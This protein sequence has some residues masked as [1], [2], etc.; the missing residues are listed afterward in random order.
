M[1]TGSVTVQNTGGNLVLSVPVTLKG[2]MV[3]LQ[4][5]FERAL[6][7]LSVDTGWVQTGTLSVN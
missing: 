3:G 4:K 7:V 6:T 1:N 2:P 5:L